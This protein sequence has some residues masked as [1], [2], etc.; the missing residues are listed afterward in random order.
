MLRTYTLR[1]GATMSAVLYQ[2][3]DR[4]RAGPVKTSRLLGYSYSTYAQYK[5]GR[6]DMTP[7]L[8]AHVKALMA[9]TDE[10]LK[11][12]LEEAVNGCC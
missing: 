5:N 1:T 3:E 10:E 6:R 7:Y 12:Q 9:L 4:L 8:V 2:L 11:K